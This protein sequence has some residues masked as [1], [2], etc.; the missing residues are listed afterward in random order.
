[1]SPQSPDGA[2]GAAPRDPPPGAPRFALARLVCALGVAQIVA[3]GTLFY[4]IAVLGPPMARALHVPDTGLYGSF[5]AGLVVSGLLAPWAGR[6]IDRR[7]GR[8]VLTLGSLL[9]TLA[10]LLLAVAWN[11][12]VM[13]AGWIIAGAAMAMCLYDAA[14]ATLHR[15]AG[16]AYR[17]AVT[18]LT[19]FGG[20]ASTVF[21]PLSQFLLERHGWRVAFGVH[22]A[23]NLAVALPLHAIFAPG[24]GVRAPAQWVA[25][26]LRDAVAG[27][28]AFVW[29]ASALSLA[30]FLAAG[31]STHLVTLLG[32]GGIAPRDAVLIGALIGPMQVVGRLMEFA[33]ARR[34]HPIRVGTLAFSLMAAALIVLAVV[35]GAS[36]AALAFAL[37]YGWSNGVMTIVRG[38]VPGELFGQRDFG[39]LLGR[40]ARPQFLL[41]SIAPLAVT[42]LF[43]LDS[44]HR[45]AL[46]LLAVAAVVALVAYQLAVRDGRR[47]PNS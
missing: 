9:A 10:C 1:M 4:S 47:G 29:L 25:A 31:L 26:G 41:K 28:R 17:R 24:T 40:L 38:T 22:A 21:W 33:F 8:G 19:L 12:W 30:A 2:T 7:G 44:T 13:A 5:T 36:G 32:A 20:F 46:V 16:P 15:V 14:F 43:G 11:G 39:A 42:L 6:R 34:V 18:A 37:L 45:V 35:R 27:K 23:V 3:W